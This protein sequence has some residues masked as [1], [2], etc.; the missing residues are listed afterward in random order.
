V[1]NLEGGK[2]ILGA[3]GRCGK[4][5]KELKTKNHINNEQEKY[6]ISSLLIKIYQKINKND[7]IGY[8]NKEHIPEYVYLSDLF[9]TSNNIYNKNKNVIHIELGMYAKQNLCLYIN[10]N[11][12]NKFTYIDI[13]NP[14][15]SL[16]AYYVGLF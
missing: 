3:P 15:E 10:S 14:D 12:N 9:W 16:E 1:G 13:F 4:I 5:I 8:V 6:M 7:T 11:S 2:K